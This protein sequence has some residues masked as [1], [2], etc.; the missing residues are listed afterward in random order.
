MRR[1]QPIILDSDEFRRNGRR[2]NQAAQVDAPQDADEISIQFSHKVQEAPKGDI[3]EDI[4]PDD[5]AQGQQ[6]R[7]DFRLNRNWFRHSDEEDIDFDN[8]GFLDQDENFPEHDE[9]GAIAFMQ[10][11]L[12]DIQTSENQAYNI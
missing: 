1:M 5:P 11:G 3:E 2:N 12:I 7:I 4:L 10:R 6:P 8:G 9:V